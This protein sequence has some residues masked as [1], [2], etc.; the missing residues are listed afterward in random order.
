MILTTKEKK[1]VKDVNAVLAKCPSP[2][3][4]GFT[5]IGDK[6]ISIF[7]QSKSQEIEEIMTRRGCFNAIA[8]ELGALA[9][10]K[11][12][13]P[14]E[15]EATWGVKTMTEQWDGRP[16]NPERDGW[17]WLG[18]RGTKWRA[19]FEWR[20]EEYSDAADEWFWDIEEDPRYPD[21][22]KNFIYLGPCPSPEELAAR[23]AATIERCIAHLENNAKLCEGLVANVLRANADSLRFMDTPA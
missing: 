18:Q 9:P 14:S 4:L 6:E 23:D 12:K 15:V 16:Q 8:D 10:E 11:I 22:M 7:D 19:P 1:W 13:F 5:T 21:E 20:H 2:D 3:K 17:H